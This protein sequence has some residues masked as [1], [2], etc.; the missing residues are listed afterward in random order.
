VHAV[1]SSSKAC[2]YCTSLAPQHHGQGKLT[3]SLLWPSNSREVF[4]QAMLGKGS[5]GQIH[6]GNAAPAPR[7]LSITVSLNRE[8]HLEKLCLVPFNTP[9][10]AA[11]G[12]LSWLSIQ[13]LVLTQVLISQV[14]RS[15]PASGSTPRGSL[16]GYSLPLP[17]PRLVHACSLS[18]PPI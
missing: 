13:L 18:L 6:L 5:Q 4:S 10:T 15:S 3:T 16:L 9:S 11:P 2:Q 7:G 12:Q 1:L 8:H 14:V 17:L